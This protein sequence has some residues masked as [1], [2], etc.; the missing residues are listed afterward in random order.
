MRT[1]PKTLVA[2]AASLMV[3]AAAS[4][5]PASAASAEVGVTS[6]SITVGQVSTLSGPVPGLF[7]G[8]KYGTLAYLSYVNSTGG[9]DGRKLLLDAKDDQF[10]SANYAADTKELAASTFALVGGFSLFDA[11]G[12]PAINAAKIPDITVSLSPQRSNDQYNYSPLVLINGGWEQGPFK[13]YKQKY[14]NAIKHVGTIYTNESSA[15]TQS[16]TVLASMRSLGYKIVYQQG[17]GVF[18]TDF[19]SDMLRMKAAGVQIVYIAGEDVEAIA[20][21]VQDANR[22]GFKPVLFSTAGPA[23]DSSFIPDAGSAANGVYTDI[24]TALYGGQDAKAV[25]AVATFD[26]WMKKVA[27]NQKLDLF[28]LY[29][30]TSAELFVQALRGAG[31][32]PTR[33]A[34]FTQLDKIT[35]YNAGG[36]TPTDNP[37]QKRPATCWLLAKVSNGKW[38]RAAPSPKSGFI[39]SPGGY[40][41]PSGY[42]PFVRQSPPST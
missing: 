39:C 34:L 27:P 26:K 25:P 9:V 6:H 17:A 16:Q 12:V 24:Q 23:Y 8:A 4:P 19:T 2:T 10:S 3:W 35:S 40:H 21:M 33:K 22:V 38:E 14:G 41:Y 20:E 31:P 7:A 13:Y 37:A 11:A 32:N 29:G 15:A 18:Q 36:L 1:A 42:K 30:W 5:A 28:S